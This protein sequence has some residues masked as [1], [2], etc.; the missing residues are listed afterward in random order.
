MSSGAESALWNAAIHPAPATGSSPDLDEHREL[1]TAEP[2]RG[3][4]RRK[5]ALEPLSECHQQGVADLVAEA[6][7]DLLEAVEVHQQHAWFGSGTRVD[8]GVVQL[9]HERP[10]VG[11]SGQGIVMRLMRAFERLPRRTEHEDRRDRQQRRHHQAEVDADH[12]DRRQRDQC[13]FG[14]DPHPEASA[15]QR[16]ERDPAPQRERDRRDRRR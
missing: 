5:A 6:I 8:Q 13:S 16:E 4:V 12:P 9:I 14:G 15:Q 2:S 3:G 11:Q 7:V 10:A 1:V